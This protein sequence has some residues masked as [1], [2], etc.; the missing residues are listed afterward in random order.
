[1]PPKPIKDFLV[2][3]EEC[4]QALADLYLRL[5][6]EE[7]NEKVKLLL[8]FMKKKE[9]L[10]GLQ[11]HQYT[12]QAPPSLLET[13]LDSEFDDS[14]P[15]KCQQMELKA[16]LSLDDVV[17]LAIRFDIQ[18]ID[19]LQTAAHSSPTIKAEIALGKLANQEEETLHHVVTARHEFE[20]M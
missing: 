16:E 20:Y 6:L 3:I 10:S 5:S 12:Q 7:N 14:F 1:M 19:L 11:L 17:A 18:L 4:H 9:Q 15:I 13:D 8:D 2:Y